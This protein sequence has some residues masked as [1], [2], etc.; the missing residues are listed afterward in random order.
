MVG[1]TSL[2]KSTLHIYNNKSVYIQIDNSG[3]D[4]IHR[5]PAIS[6][7]L[8]NNYNDKRMQTFMKEY[9]K[10]QNLTTTLRYH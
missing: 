7:C 10:Q 4:W 2:L 1:M 9:L 5:F 3:L 8:A 6:I